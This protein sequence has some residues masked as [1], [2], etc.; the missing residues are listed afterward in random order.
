MTIEQISN[1]VN[2]LLPPETAMKGDKIGIQL[3]GKNNSVNKI[4]TTL[5]VTD[6]VINEAVDNKADTI[7]TFHPLIFLPLENIRY[8]DRVGRALQKLIKNDINLISVHTAYDAFENG[9]SKIIADKLGL[10]VIDFLIPDKNYDNK[11]LG[12]ITELE[13]T[14]NPNQ[15]LSLVSDEL[16]APLRYNHFDNSIKRIAILGGSGSSFIDDA[17][18]NN[19]DAF[20][21]ADVTYHKFHYVTDRIMIIDPGHYE[22]EQFVAEGLKLLLKDN[23]DGKIEIITT[24]VLTNPVSYYPSDDKYKLRQK[25]YLKNK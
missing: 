9:T 6:E 24:E 16:N 19:C 12:L 8:E 13:N 3:K 1:I 4:L 2:E 23:I 14:I 25:D 20:I 15:L 7:I 10:D 21:T 17:L 22:M 11:G 18:N 5:E